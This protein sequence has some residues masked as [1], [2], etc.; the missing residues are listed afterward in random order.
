MS[1]HSLAAAVA[2]LLAASM[3]GCGTSDAYIYQPTEQASAM[4]EGRP[5]ARYAVPPERPTG[6]VRVTSFG[7]PEVEPRPGGPR[8][9]VL[10]ARLVVANNLDDTPWTAD[11]RHQYAWIEGEGKARPVF[12]NSD[13]P[14]A[15]IKT[16]ARGE[17]RT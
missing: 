15:P 12:A 10:H 17:Q 7:I 1:I 16:I 13:A 5:A 6:D 11:T 8:V 4:L 3:S 9:K 14:G 2:V